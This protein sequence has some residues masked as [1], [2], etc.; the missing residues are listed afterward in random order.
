M[1]PVPFESFKSVEEN[2]KVFME[3]K[4]IGLKF[5][6]PEGWEVISTDEHVINQKCPNYCI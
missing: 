4:D 6:V 3:N 2:G 5:M 1:G